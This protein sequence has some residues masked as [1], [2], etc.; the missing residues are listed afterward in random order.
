MLY[1]GFHVLDCRAQT[2][3]ALAQSALSQVIADHGPKQRQNEKPSDDPQAPLENASDA[4]RLQD[5]NLW[6]GCHCGILLRVFREVMQAQ[7]PLTAIHAEL[8]RRQEAKDRE[9]FALLI[10]AYLGELGGKCGCS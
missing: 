10:L 9:G 7:A 4:G 8:P 5:P 6:G 3:L 1:V 2:S